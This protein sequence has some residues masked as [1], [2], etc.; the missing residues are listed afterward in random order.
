LQR[1]ISDLESPPPILQAAIIAKAPQRII[2]D[3]INRFDSISIKDSFGR[4]PIYVAIEKG[5]EWTEGM[6]EVIEAI[7]VKQQRPIIHVAAQYGLSWRDCMSE[8]VKSNVDDVVNGTDSLT[9]LRLFMLAAMDKN[10]D[11]SSIYG[12]MRMSPS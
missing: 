2:A 12:M 7:S 5:L 9:G 10:S 11:L 8:L 3:I 6:Q 1:A 4:Y